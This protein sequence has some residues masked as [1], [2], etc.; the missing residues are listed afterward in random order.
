MIKSIVRN[1]ILSLILLGGVLGFFWCVGAIEF[2]V[3]KFP[4]LW[5]PLGL[6]T[7]KLLFD[8]CIE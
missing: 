1:V 6:G 8:F 3:N 5:I 4:I 7:L 2:L